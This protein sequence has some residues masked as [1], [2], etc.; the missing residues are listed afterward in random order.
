[1]ETSHIISYSAL[2]ISALVIPGVAVTLA[3]FPKK[4]DVRLSERFGLSLVFGI[5]PFFLLYFLSKNAGLPITTAT[6]QG[7]MAAVTIAGLAIWKVRT[8]A[9]ADKP[10]AAQA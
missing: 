2:I 3:L 10:Q 5:L 6:S 7:M 8:A 9:P 1:M 4:D